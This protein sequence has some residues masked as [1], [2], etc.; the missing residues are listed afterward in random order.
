MLQ[1]EEVMTLNY[2]TLYIMIAAQL[3]LP[4]FLVIFVIF[5]TFIYATIVCD[6]NEIR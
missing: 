2:A 3:R 1:H 4:I 5:I 6:Q